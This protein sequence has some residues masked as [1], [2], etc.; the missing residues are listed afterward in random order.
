MLFFFL[1]LTDKI[2]YRIDSDSG[3]VIVTSAGGSD[4]QAAYL[5]GEIITVSPGTPVTLN[6]TGTLLAV[7]GDLA[8]SGIII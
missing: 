1:E 6:G 7:N 3:L 8:I 2:T 4:L 5:N